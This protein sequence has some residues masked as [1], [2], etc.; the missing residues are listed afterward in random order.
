M[1]FSIC[2]WV[3]ACLGIGLTQNIVTYLASVLIHGL[4]TA[5][6]FYVWSKINIE[7]VWLFFFLQLFWTQACPEGMG[8]DWTHRSH[9]RCH[10]YH[11]HPTPL[12]ST[13]PTLVEQW[14]GFCGLTSIST[15]SCRM[16]MSGLI[17]TDFYKI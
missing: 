5:F 8:T 4:Q 6:S 7:L 1:L 16:V 11:T 9:E 10:P 15:P 3:L 2:T 14:C 13:P 12:G 17:T